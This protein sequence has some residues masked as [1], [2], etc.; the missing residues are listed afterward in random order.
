MRYMKRLFILLVTLLMSAMLQAQDTAAFVR[1]TPPKVGV[2][3]GGGGAKGAAHIGVLKYMEEIGIPVSY[4]SGTSIGSIIGGLYSLGYSPDEMAELIANIDW[5]FYMSNSVGRKYQSTSSRLNADT[6]LFKVPFGTGNFEERSSNFLSTLPSGVINGASLTNLFNSL[7]VG[8]QDSMDFNDYP[9]PFACVATDILNGDSVVFH[10]GEFSTALRSS[11]A[12]PGVFSPVQWNG[13]LLADGGLK[14]NFPVDVCKQMGADIV[15]GVELADELSVNLS[16]LQSLPQQMSQY[17]SIAVQGESHRHRHMCDVYMHPDVSGY[18]MLSFN[19]AAID[20][21]VKRGYECARQHHDELMAVKAQLDAFGVSGKHLQ[22]PPARRLT[23]ADTIVLAS[24][25]YRGVP[26]KE[27]DWLAR[28]GGLEVGVPLTIVD[29]ERAIGILSGTGAFSAITYKMRKTEEEYWLTHNVF[30][31]V[32][33][34]ESFDM[35]IMLAPAEPHSFALGFR[36]DSE[37]SANLLFHFAWNKQRLSGFKADMDINLKYNF[38][39]KVH[40]SWS[41]LGLGTINLAYRYHSSRYDLGHYDG[42][43]AW[44]GWQVDH[45]NFSLYFSEFQLRDFSF[46]FGIDED[47]YS[48]HAAFSF[49]NALNEGVFHFD[50]AK[51]TLGLFLRGVY[52]NLDDAYFA[53]KGSRFR[54]NAGWRK[55]NE[56]IFQKEDNGFVDVAL[57]WQKYYSLSRQFVVVPQLYARTLINYDYDW[58]YENIVGGTLPGRYMDHQMPF[59]G[60]NKPVHVGDWAAVVRLDLRYNIQG[61]FY[62]YLIGNYVRSAEEFTHFFSTEKDCHGNFGA[63]VRLAYASVIGPLSIDLHW[64]DYNNRLGAYINI[65]YVF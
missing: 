55:D 32:L 35:E 27:R 54:Y 61:R 64:N 26:E 62:F 40:A 3:L 60:F 4:V 9:I 56:T 47:L 44:I 20:A 28:K 21:L 29:I 22:A 41:T 53:T 11:M 13:H 38:E 39:Y 63:A 33:G 6:Y 34:R 25:T 58:I 50:R 36:Y 15:I 1:S 59:V 37:E 10:S 30:T 19:A 2:V 42:E 65:G 7:S 46:A 8:Y 16:D 24:V 14:D 49:S 48:N 18:N 51:G 17:I 52:D 31:D 5:S 23:P 43:A 12:I 57:S 45:N